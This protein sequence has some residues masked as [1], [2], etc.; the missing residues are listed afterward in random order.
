L[1][2]LVLWGGG[3]VCLIE[4]FIL[5]EIWEQDKTY[6]FRHFAWMIYFTYQL[7][8]VLAPNYK[9]HIFSVAKLGKTT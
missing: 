1:A 7:V 8:P 2:L 3:V 4:I 5:N 9:Q 6:F